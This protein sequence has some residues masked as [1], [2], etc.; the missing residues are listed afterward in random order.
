MPNNAPGVIFLD[1]IQAFISIT[2]IG[3]SALRNQGKGV[4]AASREF[5][6]KM[7]LGK[8]SDINNIVKF[9]ILL[10]K[11]TERLLDN[12]SFRKRPWGTARKAINLFLRDALYNKYLSARYQLEE[13]EP[14]L[15]V[16]LD[17]AVSKG[18]RKRAGRGVLPQW[19]GMKSLTKTIS[20]NYQVF[21]QA[22]A[23]ELKIHRIHLDIYLWLENR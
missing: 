22:I 19:P 1:K 14:F 23:K 5:C 17:S 20:D 21:A 11:D 4:L 9:Q 15:E 3:A 10:N 13:I 8:Y 12:F 2:A 16:P 18:L 7:D 6:A